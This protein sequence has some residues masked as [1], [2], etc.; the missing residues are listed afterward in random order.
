MLTGSLL[1]LAL[2]AAQPAPADAAGATDPEV[3]AGAP[4]DDYGLVAWCQGALTGHMEM[5]ELV[6]PELEALSPG[7][8]DD[9]EVMRQAGQ[10]YLDLYAR[11][12]RAAEKASVSPIQNRGK[13][14]SSAGYALWSQAKGFDARNRMWAYL[15]WDLPGRCEVAARR[16]EERSSLFGEALRPGSGQTNQ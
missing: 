5:R 7:A 1:A 4:A 15:M 3:P 13:Q 16:L 11:A 9:D 10:E 8:P 12:L 14:A 6:K 2:A